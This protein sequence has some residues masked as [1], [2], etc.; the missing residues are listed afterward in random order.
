[1]N[2]EGTEQTPKVILDK[3]NNKFEISG[4]SF[5]TKTKEFY[6]RIHA[7][8]DNYVKEPNDKTEFV[9]KLDY[10]DTSSSKM[11]YELLIKLD[12]L[13]DADCEA[14][15]NWLYAEDDVDM[16][17]DGED[18]SSIVKVPFVFTPYKFTPHT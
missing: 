17:E 12:K 9:F 13:L 15:V 1:M 3:E 16:R 11:I 18:Y 2:I 5:P 4:S 7:W 10:Y 14:K 6:A 8:I